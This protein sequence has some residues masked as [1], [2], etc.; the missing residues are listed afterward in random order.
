M[1]RRHHATVV[2]A[3]RRRAGRDAFV[4]P[5]KVASAPIAPVRKSGVYSHLSWA[6]GGFLLGAVCWHMVGFWTFIDRIL[7]EVPHQTA[8]ATSGLPMTPMTANEKLAE[9]L[10]SGDAADDCVTRTQFAEAAETVVKPCAMPVV[11]MQADA[12]TATLLQFG[13]KP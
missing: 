2:H 4:S 6:C 8:A 10:Y 7:D 5:R 11:A 3:T 12:P 9:R 13:E 1:I